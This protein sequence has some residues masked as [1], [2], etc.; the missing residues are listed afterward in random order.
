MVHF[1]QCANA[2]QLV[3][4]RNLLRLFGHIG[5]INARFCIFGYYFSYNIKTFFVLQLQKYVI[6]IFLIK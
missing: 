3:N 1:R 4:K 5:G 6:S 2:L